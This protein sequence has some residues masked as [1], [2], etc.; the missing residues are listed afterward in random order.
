MNER[1]SDTKILR[2]YNIQWD[3]SGEGLTKKE[4]KEILKEL[5]TETEIEVGS[6]ALKEYDLSPDATDEEIIS[7]DGLMDDISDLVSDMYG[8]LHAGFQVEVVGRD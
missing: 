7:N 5:P 4:E 3:I 2:V 1:K 8:F 6:D